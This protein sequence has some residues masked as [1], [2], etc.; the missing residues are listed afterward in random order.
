MTASYTCPVVKDIVGGSIN[1]ALVRVVDQNFSHNVTCELWT[2][3]ADG[4]SGRWAERS[5]S[6]TNPAPQLLTFGALGTPYAG[7]SYITCRLPPRYS[8]VPSKIISY[9]VD[10]NE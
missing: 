9:Q 10:E 1:R 5:S 8:G 4:T 2:Y 6:G 7:F 3:A